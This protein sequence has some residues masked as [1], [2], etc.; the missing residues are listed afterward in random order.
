MP[1]LPE[2]ETTRRGLAP[3]VV[4]RS[5]AAVEVR[6]P[7]LRWPV[8]K[9]LA[10]SARRA[11]HRRARAA[12]QVSLVRHAAPA[13][14]W[15]T[16]ACP[17][18]FAISPIRR[19][20]ARTITSTWCSRAAAAAFQRPAPL[21]Q[22]AAHERHR[23]PIRCLKP[24]GPEPLSSDFTAD[25]LADASRGRRVAIKP[26]LMNGRIVVGVG[27][28]YA[29]EALFRAGIHPLRAAGRS[30]ARSGSRRSSTPCALCCRRARGR[31][32]HAAQLRRRRWQAR[33]TSAN[34]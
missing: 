8:A 9:T 31:R 29:N 7:R 27:N 1:E 22:L 15:C 32:H 20:T 4:G 17:A 19:R 18:A 26:H 28:I 25:Y 3:Y 14:C 12:R 16:S 2:V 23:A 10:S 6:E 33:A 30:S 21:R 24:L 34:R 13:R 11:A 5:I